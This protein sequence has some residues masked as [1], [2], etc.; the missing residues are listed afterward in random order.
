MNADLLPI[1]AALA[2]L[3]D[4][5]LRAVVATANEGRQMAP[6]LLAWIEHAADCRRAGTGFALQPSDAAIDPSEDAASVAAT[7]MLHEQFA[8]DTPS[9]GALFAA[10]LGALTRMGSLN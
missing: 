3:T 5:E 6:G 7:A 10:I 9:V 8:Q 2:E 4:D 1:V